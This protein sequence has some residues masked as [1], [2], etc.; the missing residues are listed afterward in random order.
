ML[1]VIFLLEK[2]GTKCLPSRAV[3][4]IEYDSV[5]TVLGP[6]EMPPKSHY[7]IVVCSVLFDEYVASR[8]RVEG[9]RTL[10]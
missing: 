4:R 6:E 2:G 5:V 10:R 3:V 8:H 1:N 9:S 7:S